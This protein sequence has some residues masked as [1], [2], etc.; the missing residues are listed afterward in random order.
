MSKEKLQKLELTWIGKNEEPKLEPRI[1]L[2][3]PEYNY[4]NNSNMLIHGD[5]LLALKALEADFAGQVKCIYIDPPYNTGSAFEHYDD[6]L[7]HS[8]WL[9]LMV[10]RLRILWNLLSEDGLFFCSID[11]KEHPYLQVLCDEIFGRNN[12][13]S[14]IVWKKVSSAKSQSR[15]VGNVVEYILVY[16]KTSDFVFNPLFLKSNEE[17]DNKNYPHT[18]EETGRRYGSFDFTQK[19]QGVARIFWGETLEP[20]AGKHWIWT[21]EKIDEGIQQGLIFKT[22]NGVPRLKRYLDN[23][24]GNFISDLWN[25]DDVAPIGAN[26]KE[27]MNFFGQKSEGLIKRILEIA[28][29]PG[30]LVLDSFLGSGTTAAVAHKMGRRYIGIELGDHCYTHCLPRLQ[31]VV[32]GEQGGISKAVGWQGGGGFKFYELAASLLKK[33][34]YGEWIISPEYNADMLAAAM[35]KQEGF[36]YQPHATQFWKQ[37]QSSEQ[38]F[39]FTTTQFVTVEMLDAISDEMQEGESLLICS[40]SFQKE[41]KGKYPNI[42]IKKIPLMLLGRCEFD[43][44]DYSMN[45][46]NLPK[47]NYSEKDGVEVETP[48]E[49]STPP[50][51]ETYQISFFDDIQ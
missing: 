51:P 46:V 37:G 34:K 43:H 41:C 50:K 1:L 3:K 26:A 32:D 16:S 29:N 19:G 24:K 17:N 44:D 31:K 18:E 33:D 10:P 2:E 11:D 47:Y 45:I 48:I 5:N 23:K 4:G 6:K 42:T 27:A 38:D 30:D 22:S 13:R 35:A 8:T 12:F 39:I 9:S 49:D 14:N 21:Q 40:R 28:T 7:E 36:N 15:F 20:P 25:D